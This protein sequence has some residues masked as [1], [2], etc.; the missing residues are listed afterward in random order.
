MK[1]IIIKN[2]ITSIITLFIG[3][4]TVVVACLYIFQKLEPGTPASATA[5]GFY[6][7]QYYTSDSNDLVGISSFVICAF[8]I[9]NILQKRDEMPLLLI[10]LYAIFV[11]GTTVTF[12]TTALFL[13]PSAA[14]NG[15]YYFIMFEGKL[16][17][18]HFLNPVLAIITLVFFIN[19][20]PLT[21]KHAIHCMATVVIYSFVYSPLV[22]TGVW[23]DFYGF[24]FGGKFGLATITFFVMWGVGLGTGF[25][26]VFLHNLYYQKS[27]K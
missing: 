17:F 13:G 22:L 16:F 20:H 14:M 26:L 5:A 23:K 15:S 2:I 11:T 21:W 19:H 7:F 1:N 4:S 27:H 24:T 18:L 8:A 6:F 12:L 9:K 3:I 10:L 25:L